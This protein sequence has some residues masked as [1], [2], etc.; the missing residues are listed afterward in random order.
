MEGEY[1]AALGFIL[2]MFCALWGLGRLIGPI[3]LAPRVL[4]AV[5]TVYAVLASGLVLGR[6]YSRF[7]ERLEEA[8]DAHS[9][10]PEQY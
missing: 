1:I 10:D 3:P 5:A 9:V 6:L 8:C 4:Y 2:A 7:R